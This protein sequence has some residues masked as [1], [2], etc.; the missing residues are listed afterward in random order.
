LVEAYEVKSNTEI[1]AVLA[2][3]SKKR[4]KHGKTKSNKRQK[5]K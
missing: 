2:N 5:T 1:E 4:K 3:L